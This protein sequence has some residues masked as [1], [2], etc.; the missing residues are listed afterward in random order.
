[1]TEERWLP[2][3]GYESHYEVSDRGRVRRIAPSRGTRVG[4]LLRLTPDD[5][6]YPKVGLSVAG[7]V[8]EIHVHR[9]VALAF[10]GPRVDRLTVN[11]R[12][13]VKTNNTIENLEYVTYA[14]NNAHAIRTGLKQLRGKVTKTCE[15]CA[16]TFDVYPSI[17]PLRR[18][19]SNACRAR[20]LKP[21]L[22]TGR[23]GFR[24]KSQ[25]AGEATA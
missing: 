2:V 11:H 22:G 7:S 19:C 16:R 10:I 24:R 12:D 17:A 6:G 20:A 18:F 23:N 4:R 21:R 3:V 14:E 13:G 15:F 25:I 8:L 1:V 9:L 5:N